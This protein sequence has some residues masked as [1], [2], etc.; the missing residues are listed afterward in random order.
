MSGK[1]T[2]ITPPDFYENGNLSILFCHLSDEEQDNVTK[3]L[4]INILKDDIN[5]YFYS[6]ETN[7]DWFLYASSRCE[8]KY[9]NIDYVNYITQALSGFI[10]SKNN[11]Y[12]KTS[13][14][15][16]ANVYSYI[17]N[18]QVAN[19]EQFLESVLGDQ[20]KSNNML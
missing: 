16:L 2:L 4:S 7:I 12:H 11:T 17:N 18:K 14:A 8:Y 20:T 13:D 19:V 1:I 9:I 6:G 5:I 10:L 3:W 15:N